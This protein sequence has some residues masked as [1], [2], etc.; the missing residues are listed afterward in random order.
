MPDA[1][2]LEDP[3]RQAP[4]TGTLRQVWPGVL[5]WAGATLAVEFG[6]FFAARAMAEPSTVVLTLTAA[7]LWVILAAPLACCGGPTLPAVFRAAAIV[8]ATALTLIVLA[9]QSQTVS[10]GAAVKIYLLICL[11]AAAPCAW[12]R[13]ARHPARQKAI[14]LVSSVLLLVISAGPFWSASPVLSE[15]HTAGRVGFDLLMR[16]NPL[17]T[18]A[19]ILPPKHLVWQEREILYGFTVLGRDR[20]APEADWRWAC[21][22]YAVLAVLGG[23]L[24]AVRLARLPDKA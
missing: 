18:V 14:A 22:I 8:D 3:C 19:S 10:A 1:H 5:A 23:G 21:A 6:G 12:V 2:G 4:H 9:A 15:Q 20:A 24:A 17:L 13:L 7:L 16:A 11:L